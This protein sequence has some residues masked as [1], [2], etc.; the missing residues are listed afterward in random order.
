MS[1]TV[2]KT[3]LFVQD[4]KFKKKLEKKLWQF[5]HLYLSRKKSD[6]I[7]QNIIF[8]LTHLTFM[9]MHTIFRYLR[10]SVLFQ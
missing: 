3:P 2:L 6:P 4:L 7:F 1:S 5:E 10:Q 9:Y 8:K